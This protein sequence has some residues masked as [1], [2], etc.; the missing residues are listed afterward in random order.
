MQHVKQG[1][2][3]SYRLV[4]YEDR[5]IHPPVSFASLEELLRTLASVLPD[6]PVEKVQV[7]EQAAGATYIAYAGEWP[8][9]DAQLAQLESAGE[10][11][12]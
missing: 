8:M 3:W 11:G 6:F 5:K 7:R 10:S 12:R 4:T 2:R 1:E 9:D